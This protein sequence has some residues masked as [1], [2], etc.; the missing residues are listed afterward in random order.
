M[1]KAQT[2]SLLSQI[3][4][5]PPHPRI[6]EALVRCLTAPSP[7]PEELRWLVNSDPALAAAMCQF[8]EPLRIGPAFVVD[9]ETVRDTLAFALRTWSRQPAPG[10]E[11]AGRPLAWLRHSIA[12]AACSERISARCRGANPDE[13]YWAGLLHDLGKLAL[14]T[15]N[16]ESYARIIRAAEHGED[17]LV[18]LERREF[19]I[20]HAAAGKHLLER[21][22]APRPI[23]DAA[24]LHHHPLDALNPAHF[25][26][27]LIDVVVLGSALAHELEAGTRE[28]PLRRHDARLDR[29]RLD[30]GTLDLIRQ[31]A[32]SFLSARLEHLDLASSGAPSYPVLHAMLG[33]KPATG[34]ER[35][36]SSDRS[37]HPDAARDFLLAADPELPLDSI[38]EHCAR[39]VRAAFRIERGACCALNA[40]GGE[41]TGCAW[42]GD[43]GPLRHFAVKLDDGRGTPA[44]LPA[45]LETTNAY[46]DEEGTAKREERRRSPACREA[47]PVIVPLL[48]RGRVIGYLIAQPK[49]G[50]ESPWTR[51]EMCELNDFAEC[52]AAAIGRHHTL[53]IE[54]ARTESL[55]EALLRQSSPISAGPRPPESP[56][57]A[58]RTRGRTLAGFAG[59][60]ARALAGPLGAISSQTQQLGAA[61]GDPQVQAAARQILSESRRLNRLLVDLDALADSTPP[62]FEPGLLN[63]HVRQFAGAIRTRLEKKRI[64]LTEYYA[65]GLPRVQIDGRKLD[66]AFF[67]LLF[68]AEQAMSE[69][70]GEW[71]IQTSA[72]L[73]RGWVVLR[74]EDT[75]RAIPADELPRI[76][77]PFGA[78]SS[79]LGLAVCR[80][81]VEEHGGRIT[82]ESTPGKGNAFTILL[83]SLHTQPAAPTAAVAP[84]AGEPIRNEEGKTRILV[85]DDDNSTRDVLRKML[86]AR[87]YCAEVADDG[88]KAL[89]LIDRRAADIILL[90]LLMPN[91]DGFA[92]LEEL[93]A[94]GSDLPV[95]VMTGSTSPAV[96][97]DVLGLGADVVL[98]KPFEFRQ[99]MV[100]LENLTVRRARSG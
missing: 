60:L 29:L 17:T 69:N 92:V 51:E 13:A 31:D 82:V 57:P 89:E 24:W 12:T 56:S 22:G 20:D 26:V 39:A 71:V 46:W 44:A 90:D 8:H 98:Q 86:E 32:A 7:C 3:A 37:H 10:V 95:I 96:Q 83:P 67:N 80:A 76:F 94:R 91:R 40:V 93:R 87:G 65:E 75:A 4:C 5:L 25:P 2:I 41:L 54:T 63:Y 49:G 97:E 66:R 1:D 38:L 11:W 81:I 99:L 42:S 73:D 15:L 23:V 19:G 85:V 28:L 64:K 6:A 78:G 27:S 33:S 61:G 77:E 52:I 70:G 79:E 21:W 35:R 18:A 30:A 53:M 48:G 16:A 58:P 62:K 100:E 88:R 59:G 84:P 47:G 14:H 50:G 34:F 9:A 72:S 36:A 74:F 43:M 68:W 55:A 45:V